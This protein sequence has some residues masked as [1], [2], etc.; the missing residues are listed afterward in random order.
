LSS[1]RELSVPSPYTKREDIKRYIRS[2]V[3]T[4]RKMRSWKQERKELV[5]DVLTKQVDGM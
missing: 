3:T 4:N 1:I 2:V 5:I